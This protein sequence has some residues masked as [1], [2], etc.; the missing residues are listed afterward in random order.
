MRSLLCPGTASYQ[1]LNP[2]DPVPIYQMW[3]LKH[4]EASNFAKVTKLVES[5]GLNVAV[6]SR[7]LALLHRYTL[8]VFPFTTLAD[9]HLRS[10]YYVSGPVHARIQLSLQLSISFKGVTGHDLESSSL[11]PLLSLSFCPQIV[12]E[13]TEAGHSYY[14]RPW[15]HSCLMPSFGSEVQLF[16]CLA[17]RGLVT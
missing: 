11:L 10:T 12:S 2:Y 5:L 3:R 9:C 14:D 17:G 7:V 15:T 4:R 1:S 8:L 6:H 13:G 16:S